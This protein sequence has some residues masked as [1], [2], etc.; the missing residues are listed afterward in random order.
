MKI[1]NVFTLSLLTHSPCFYTKATVHS[2]SPVGPPHGLLDPQITE[3]VFWFNSRVPCI[4]KH[5]QS[6]LQQ[7][8]AQFCDSK[9]VGMAGAR[10]AQFVGMSRHVRHA[11]G[12]SRHSFAARC[13]RNN[14]KTTRLNTP[15]VSHLLHN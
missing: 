6:N 14:S 4:L 12:L 8:L 5:S 15:L 13:D 3:S 9:L 11:C 7:L 1:I 2:T 10:C